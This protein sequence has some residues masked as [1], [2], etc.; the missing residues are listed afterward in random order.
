VTSPDSSVP[1]VP[2]KPAGT[3]EPTF[4]SV[5]CPF[6]EQRLRI[7]FYVEVWSGSF[8]HASGGH[9]CPKAPVQ[10]LPGDGEVAA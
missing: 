4:R 6:C 3:E 9:V 1:A 5:D 10:S 8:V 2:T 7:S